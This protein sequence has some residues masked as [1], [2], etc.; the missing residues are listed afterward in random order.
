MAILDGA[1]ALAAADP[2]RLVQG[3][4]ADDLPALAAEA[5]A[6][7]PVVV[8]DTWVL[9][10]VTTERR[11]AFVRALRRVAAE[12]RAPAWLI[13]SRPSPAQVSGSI[14]TMKVERVSLKR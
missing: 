8:T 6:G 5:P 13:S 1:V 11:L 10:Y 2:A 7:M 9:A 14:S 3:D 4:L 12:R